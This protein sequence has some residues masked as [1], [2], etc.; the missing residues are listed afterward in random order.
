MLNA[1]VGFNFKRSS[2][3]ARLSGRAFAL[4]MVLQFVLQSFMPCV[5]ADQLNMDLSSTDRT[6]SADS[7]FAG[8]SGSSVSITVN[9]N[10]QMVQGGDLITPAEYLAASQVLSGQTQTL[11]LG[12]MGI[13]TGKQ[14]G[15]AHV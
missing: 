4:I 3:R 14:I 1:V 11:M 12:A 6:V 8:A 9:G 2:F 15:R 10:T 7:L 13:V 5:W